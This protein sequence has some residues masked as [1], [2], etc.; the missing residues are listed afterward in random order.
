[1]MRRYFFI[2]LFLAAAAAAQPICR[3]VATDTVMGADGLLRARV[4]QCPT[5]ITSGWQ[6]GQMFIFIPDVRSLDGASIRFSRILP[7][8]KWTG[9]LDPVGEGDLRPGAAGEPQSYLVVWM[10]EYHKLMPDARLQSSGCGTPGC[11][12]EIEIRFR[13]ANGATNSLGR[14]QALTFELGQGI[15]AIASKGPAAGEVSL[16]LTADTAVLLTKKTQQ[17]EPL[18]V[19]AAS[20][21]SGTAYRCAL[22]PPASDYPSRQAL[23]FV[24][25]VVNLGDPT[26][27]VDGL[28]P[29]PLRKRTSLGLENLIRAD[30]APGD[31]Y[32]LLAAPG[33]WIVVP[34]RWQTSTAAAVRERW[35]CCEIQTDT[36]T[37]SLELVRF[38]DA[39]IPYFLIA[40]PPAF[41]MDGRWTRVF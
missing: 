37:A 19:C 32:L 29:R 11:P 40:A 24:P 36:G 26:L 10:G 17:R 28:G 18:P 20:S 4:Y 38:G 5:S 35:R 6:I 16:S 3:G 12:G 23:L 22:L 33:Y 8:R 39:D 41:T 25:D 1:M 31:S 2:Y 27:D 34:L 7:I 21:G 30:L 13:G 14:A 15:N 9:S